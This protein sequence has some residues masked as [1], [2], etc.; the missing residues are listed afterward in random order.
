MN[1]N[2]KTLANLPVGESARVFFLDSNSQIKRRLL[3]LGL[4][5][6]AVIKAVQSSPSGEFVA[7]LIRGAV[8]AIRSEDA[9]FV[10][11]QND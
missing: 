4:T 6:G 1:K 10:I 7:Y 2:V 11:L 8:I 5:E 3:D 9:C